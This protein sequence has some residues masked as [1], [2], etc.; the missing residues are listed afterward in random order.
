VLV[1]C[2]GTEP[3]TILVPDAAFPAAMAVSP[4]SSWLYYGERLTGRIVAVAGDGRTELTATVPVS[5]AGEQRGLL[6]L[7]FDQ[8][9]RLFASYTDVSTD[10]L[11]VV[12]I[13]Q[14]ASLPVWIGPSAAD[15]SNG[16]RIAFAPDGS[17]VIGVGDLLEPERVADPAAP[18]GKLLALD[19]DGPPSQAPR[20]IS[21]GWHNPFAF[22]F[23]PDGVLYVA[24][25]A[26]GEAPERLAMGD[27]G[28]RPV[29][30]AELPSHTAPSGIAAPDGRRLVVC[31]YL[32]RT[33]T[34]YSIEEGTAVPGP[35]L[36]D[37]CSL[38]VVLLADGSLVY[39]NEREIRVLADVLDRD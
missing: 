10:R 6:G 8:G 39:A 38:G 35:T 32:R 13:Q 33:L 26:P 2:S 30:L 34:T 11:T 27:A 9:A 5:T 17:L 19:A 31:S 22:A 23:A 24:D 4:K 18:N 7:A 12:R 29:V 25:N 36:A 1:L 28:P 20:V 15:R 21:S 37:D 3:S 16:G 14:H